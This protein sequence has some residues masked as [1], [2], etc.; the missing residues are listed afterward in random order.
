MSSKFAAGVQFTGGHS[1]LGAVRVEAWL[2]RAVRARPTRAAVNAMTYAELDAAAGGVARALHARDVEP[3]EPVAIALP[4]GEDFVV[5]LHALW[6]L[7]CPA[8]P[9]DLR[10]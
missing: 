9:L 6:R 1:S 7:G 2:S 3:G 4:P 8:V 10:A 5:A